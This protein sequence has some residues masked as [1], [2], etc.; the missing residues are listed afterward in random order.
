MPER[1]YMDTVVTISKDFTGKRLYDALLSMGIPFSAPCGGNGTCG[2]CRVKLLA[3][4]VYTE[5]GEAIE[6][7]ENT[8]VLSCHVFVGN[9]GCTIGVKALSGEGLTTEN[10]DSGND[11][12]TVGIALDIGT[13]TLA[14]ALVDL[15]SGAVLKTAST[16]N[17]QAPFGADVMSRIAACREGKLSLLQTVLLDS[18]R[19]LCEVLLSK[20]T[21]ERMTVVGNPTMLHIFL[22]ISPEGIGQYPF[23]P[24]FLSTETRCGDELTLPAKQVT[25]LPSASAF[26][27]SD[28]I[29]GVYQHAL[30]EFDGA[31]IL[32]DVGTNGEIVLVKDR[33]LYAA[34]CAAGPALEGARISSGMGGVAGAVSSVFEVDGAYTYTTVDDAPAIGICGAGLCDLAAILLD[35]GV[36]DDSGYLEDD[37]RLVG[38]H[39]TKSGAMPRGA[40]SVMLTASDVRELQLAKAAI[41]AGLDTLMQEA[42]LTEDA[43]L[44][45]FLAG[46]LGFYL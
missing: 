28:V 20:K 30:D 1:S 35:R 3:G 43:L 2:K 18:V 31:A 37:F 4:R 6:P 10:S 17:P 11:A 42:D 22:G 46:G 40:T 8:E 9:E 26:I 25:V 7:D 32:I 14:A 39:Q 13:T 27:G 44:S 29:A 33:A 19:S 24:T 12:A 15:D 5:G 21:A 45:L 41:R 23:T 16:L 34:S 38:V 36:I